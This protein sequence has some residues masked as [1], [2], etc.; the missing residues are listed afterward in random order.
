MKNMRTCIVWLCLSLLFVPL[1]HAQTPVPLRTDIKI[2]EVMKAKA[3]GVRIEVDPVNGWIVYATVPGEIYA[4]LEDSSGNWRDSLLYT[5]SQHGITFLQGMVF[6]DST[7]YLSGNVWDDSLTKG[8]VVAAAMQASGNRTFELMVESDWYAMATP[9]A[10]HGF[11]GLVVHPKG[12]SLYVSSGS[13]TH[14]GEVRDNNGRWPGVREVP[15]TAKVFRFSVDTRNL[16]LPNDSAQLQASGHIWCEGIRNTFSMAF[17]PFNRLFGV[18][19]SGGRDD[20]EE[21]NWLQYGHHYGF[22]W[23]M[24]GNLNPQ[25]YPNYDPAKD[26]LVNPNAPGIANGWYV[27][28]PGFPQMPAGLTITPPLSNLGPDADFIRDSITGRIRDASQ[29]GLSIKS[30]TTHRSPVGLVFD[31]QGHLGGGLM[32][33]AF[34]LSF[35]PGGDSSGYTPQSPWGSPAVPVDP[36]E[37]LLFLDIQNNSS[38]QSPTDFNA[39]RIA[40]GFL[41]PVDACLDRN[42]MYVLEYWTGTPR[43]IWKVTLPE[44]RVGNGPA[45]HQGIYLWPNPAHTWFKLQINL[46]FQQAVSVQVLDIQGRQV[47]KIHEGELDK[48][49]HTFDF[50][51]D[52]LRNG[53]YII[54]VEADHNEVWH[55]K[56]VIAKQY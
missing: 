31:W 34:M 49:S 52:D 28:D 55:E 21:L 18:D 19:N 48:G 37:D 22:P 26:K 11:S 5:A 40:E 15:L 35:M 29:E 33:G 14:H 43:S 32:H 54:R 25:Q 3:E 50:E 44:T 2:S 27:N 1:L 36:S 38:G 4:L 24:G 45:M 56:L 8:Y 9:F 7:L 6:H 16:M 20:P 39:H 53:L 41:L 13:R 10:D 12:D 23:E 30:F 47:K 42:V 17:D 46:D 51:T